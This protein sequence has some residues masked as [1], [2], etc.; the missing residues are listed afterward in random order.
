MFASS[1]NWISSMSKMKRFAQSTDKIIDI[2]VPI[3]PMELD[4]RDTFYEVRGSF[5]M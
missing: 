4:E 2:E 5:L 3:T 1:V